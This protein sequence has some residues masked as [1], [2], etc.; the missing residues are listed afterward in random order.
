MSFWK[1]IAGG[2]AVIATGKRIVS[3]VQT[4]DVS[5]KIANGDYEI[6]VLRY[7]HDHSSATREKIRAEVRA[8]MPTMKQA[9]VNVADKAIESLLQK[10]EIYKYSERTRGRSTAVIPKYALL[11]KGRARINV[12]LI[13]EAEE[14]EK[15][16][17]AQQTE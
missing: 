8:V 1:W 7:L 3:T 9:G 17:S 6:V 16:Q 2:V 5:R 12:A 14:A 4:V 13:P 11:N 10:A 15:L